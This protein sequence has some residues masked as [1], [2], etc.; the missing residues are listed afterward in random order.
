TAFL[1]RKEYNAACS[2]RRQ[3]ESWAQAL[4]NIDSRATIESGD[5]LVDD[6]RARQLSLPKTDAQGRPIKYDPRTGKTDPKATAGAPASDTT[7]AASAPVK[8]D[9][10]RTVRNVGPTFL[11]GR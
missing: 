4:K 8:P 5:I 9:P 6:Q 1:Y 10:N 3:G 2:C 11:P 7:S